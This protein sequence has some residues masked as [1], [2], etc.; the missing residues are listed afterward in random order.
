MWLLGKIKENVESIPLE[1]SRYIGKSEEDMFHSSKT[2]L[3]HN[4]HNNILTPDKIPEFCLPPRL[5]KRSP[6]VEVDTTPPSLPGQNHIPKS[7]TSSINVR[8]RRT[9]V[10]LKNGDTSETRQTAKKPLP[11]SAE[12]YGLSGIYERPNTRRKESLFHSNRP[13]YIFDRSI[14]NA[15]PNLEKT[16]D[17]GKKSISGFSCQSMLETGGT[18]SETAS[19]SDSSPLSSPH[20]SKSSLR[21]LSAKGRLKGATSCPSLIDSRE[22]GGRWR[23][24]GFSLT[25]SVSNPSNFSSLM[26]PP[27]A[28]FPTDGLQCQKRRQHESVLPLKGRGKVRLSAE[29]AAL[30][31]NTSCS[32]YTVRVHVMSVEALQDDTEQR[33]LSCAVNLCLTPGKL[34]QQR[35][36]T[37]R[38]CS[39]P[40]FNEDF[41][42]T[43][44]RSKDLLELQLKLKVVDQSAAGSLRRGAAIGVV[45]KPLSQLLSLSKQVQE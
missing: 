27:P 35:S 9:D 42:F 3:S 34:Q 21:I 43:E 22:T 18:E 25:T 38:N 20:S 28:S 45:T 5:C 31:N 15:A 29:H 10:K 23:R 14:C 24:G 13:V 30:P 12:V 33:T 16:T 2:S 40:V 4:L 44:L 37:I 17:M 1:L 8:V 26:L 7:G 11:F 6:V 39:S 19:S 41:F 32:L 36:A